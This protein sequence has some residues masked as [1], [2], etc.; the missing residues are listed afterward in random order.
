MSR[1]STLAIYGIGA[2]ACIA[3]SLA[4]L[5][6]CGGGYYND[7]YYDHHHQS[8]IE[9]GTTGE[10]T[11]A[12]GVGWVCLNFCCVQFTDD[13]STPT[14]DDMTPADDDDN[15]NDDNDASP[16]RTGLPGSVD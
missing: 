4:L 14:D 3:L 6:S 9:C 12:L 10:C 7:G 8:C 16:S 15:D 11:D 1:K 2:A 5:L 13:D